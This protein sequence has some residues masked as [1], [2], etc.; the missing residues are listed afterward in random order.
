M[1]F[2]VTKSFGKNAYVYPNHSIG[3]TYR[4]AIRNMFSNLLLYNMSSGHSSR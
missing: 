3:P 1:H 4:E 2:M